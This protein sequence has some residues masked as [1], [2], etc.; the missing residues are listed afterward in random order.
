MEAVTPTPVMPYQPVG[1]KPTGMRYGVMIFLGALAFLTYFD[2]VCIA[3]AQEFIQG[4]LHLTHDGT[5]R[6]AVVGSP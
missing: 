2:R 1:E 4:D 6:S 5:G 3:W